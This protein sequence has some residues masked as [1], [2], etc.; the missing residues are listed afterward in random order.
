MNTISE[1][2]LYNDVIESDGKVH[3]EE[4]ALGA[5]LATIAILAVVVGLFYIL[6]VL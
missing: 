6:F 2:W 4:T 5:A 1:H 3:K